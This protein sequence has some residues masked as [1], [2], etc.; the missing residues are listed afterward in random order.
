MIR[1]SHLG[2]P[3]TPTVAGAAPEPRLQ[4]SLALLCVIVLQWRLP[5]RLTAGPHW[6]LPALEAALL[7]PLTVANPYRDEEE[8][9]LARYASIGLLALV[10]IANLYSLVRLVRLLI[11][12]SNGATGQRLILSALVVWLTLVVTFGLLF[13]EF[14]RG[15][16]ARRSRP[17]P[18]LPDLTF[19][20]DANPEVGP[21]GLVA[22][23]PGLPVRRFH[24]RVRFQPDRHLAADGMGEVD[25]PQ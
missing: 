3:R 15:G 17:T 11:L 6:L 14:D 21:P 1:L 25:V 13:W 23:I 2:R 24:E 20:Q 4:S 9:K 16:P 12:G 5:D 10:H 19:P 22:G 8:T 18:P 7:V